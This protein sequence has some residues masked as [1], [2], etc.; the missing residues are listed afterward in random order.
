MHRVT[1]ERLQPG[2][3]AR[4][5][6]VRL[7]ALQ[8]APDAF[9]TTFEESSARPAE[10]WRDAIARLATFVATS[11]G[12]GDVGLVRGAPHDQSP[13]A[14]YLVSMWVAPEAR[15]QGIGAAL[16]AAVI[17][18]ARGRG[19]T[20]LVLDVAEGNERAWRLYRR[21]GFVPNGVVGALPPPR[22]HIREVQLERIL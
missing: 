19:F 21:M 7:R 14:G 11:D 9:E 15:G 8:D 16:V 2:D 4:L 13:A 12:G 3:E 22:D 5:R 18:W 17:D 1:V 6:A 10:H 20:R